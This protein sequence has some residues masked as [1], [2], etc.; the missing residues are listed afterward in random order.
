MILFDMIMRAP[1]SYWKRQ[2]KAEEL[3]RKSAEA[4]L[5][6]YRGTCDN[7]QKDLDRLSERS[8]LQ[9]RAIDAQVQ[10][11]QKL[12]DDM[13]ALKQKLKERDNEIGLLHEALR[14]ERDLNAALRTNSKLWDSLKQKTVKEAQA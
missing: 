2:H 10:E 5:S 6:Y 8:F 7:Q 9:S 13:E 3:K 1:D 4:D 14:T 12:K 11:I